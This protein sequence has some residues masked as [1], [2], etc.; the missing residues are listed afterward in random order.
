MFRIHIGA[1]TLVAAIAIQHSHAAEPDCWEA[2]SHANL[3]LQTS[4]AVAL[5]LPEGARGPYTTSDSVDYRW[6]S[7]VGVIWIR[8]GKKASDVQA[9]KIRTLKVGSEDVTLYRWRD[10]SGND[11][12]IGEWKAVGSI[13]RLASIDIPVNW[14]DCESMSMATSI[15]KS[16][17]FVN[18]PDLI[19]AEPD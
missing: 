4:P 12:L 10:Y 1:I 17:R 9:T 8:F 14:K 13:H 6:E 19:K 7:P 18:K 3:T 15:I 5:Y 11:V 16:V 2:E